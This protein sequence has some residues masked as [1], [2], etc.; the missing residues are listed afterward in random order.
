M[1]T[2][3][4][5]ELAHHMRYLATSG[6]KH[7]DGSTRVPTEQEVVDHGFEPPSY[8]VDPIPTG[9]R[10]CGIGK[11]DPNLVVQYHAKMLVELAA[12]DAKAD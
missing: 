3:S 8:L 1:K 2:K 5:R 6:F 4:E 10:I 12:A 9:P 7:P 11:S